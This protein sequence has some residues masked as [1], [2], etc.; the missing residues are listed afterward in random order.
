MRECVTAP[1]PA[2]A[3]VLPPRSFVY[4]PVELP[5]WPLVETVELAVSPD[6][7]SLR[8]SAA[9]A[10]LHREA[11]ARDIVELVDVSAL[12]GLPGAESP[13]GVLTAPLFGGRASA[14]VE[15]LFCASMVFVGGGPYDDL[16]TVPP[17]AAR[18]D[19]RLSSSG[20]L[21][22]F[23]L[24]GAPPAA[25]YAVRPAVWH[26]W[27]VVRGLLASDVPD[28]W[29]SYTGF[30]EVAAD[31]WPGCR[32]IA[33]GCALFEA[34]RERGVVAAARTVPGFVRLVG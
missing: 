1:P 29:R 34:L 33:Y 11:A 22:G 14:P 25:L 21:L 19:S 13:V 24:P 8:S 12:A 27:L 18:A 6:W 17:A 15:S 10:A 28:R 30:T 2:A 5:G 23:L 7:T 20:R 4:L 16:V 9:A 31:P 3:G 32:P 26:D